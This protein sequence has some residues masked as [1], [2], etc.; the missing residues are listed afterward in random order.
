MNWYKDGKASVK[1]FSSIL[2]A[3]PIL[4]ASCQSTEYWVVVKHQE[5]GETYWEEEAE[6]GE[7][8]TIS[9]THSVEKTLW[10]DQLKVDEEGELILTQTRFQSYGAGVDHENDE[11]VTFKDGNVVYEDINKKLDC[12]QWIHSHDAEHKVTFREEHSL[13]KELPHHEPIEICIESR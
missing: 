8:I 6:I 5:T 2:L 13:M 1:A 11:K 12:Y 9:W 3:L 7:K 4:L 10:E